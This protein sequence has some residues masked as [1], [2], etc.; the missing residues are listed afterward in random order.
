[1]SSPTKKATTSGVEPNG[2][3][4]HNT[5]GMELREGPRELGAAAAVLGEET[6]KDPADWLEPPLPI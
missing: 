5:K 4:P 6:Q 3:Q 1:M 2:A